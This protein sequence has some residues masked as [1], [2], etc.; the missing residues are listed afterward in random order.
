MLNL[1]AGDATAD[2]EHLCV[3]HV[4]LRSGKHD[5]LPGPTLEAAGKPDSREHPPVLW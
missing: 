3:S 2:Y 1:Q 4:P 5:P